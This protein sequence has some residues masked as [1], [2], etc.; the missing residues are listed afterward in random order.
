MDLVIGL[1]VIASGTAALAWPLLRWRR[2]H[3]DHW[4]SSV[5]TYYLAP[6][7]LLALISHLVVTY[8][9]PGA[10]L[11]IAVGGLMAWRGSAAA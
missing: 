7:G 5:A 11:L 6:I 10:L 1:C 8:G 9:W 4:L 2:R 3:P